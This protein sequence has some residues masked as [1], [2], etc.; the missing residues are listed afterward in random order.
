[1][2]DHK[3]KIP[4]APG[5]VEVR[6]VLASLTLAATCETC[7]WACEEEEPMVFA[8]RHLFDHHDHAIVTINTMLTVHRMIYTP[9]QG[10]TAVPHIVITRE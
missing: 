7:D 6:Q 3:K 10:G 5:E 8:A 4:T 2:T 9:I 1:M